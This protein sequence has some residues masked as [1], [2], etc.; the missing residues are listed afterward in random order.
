MR[1]SAVK[2]ALLT[3][4]CTAALFAGGDAVHLETSRISLGRFPA[5]RPPSADLVLV[6]GGA[7]PLEDIRV[8][9]GCGCL[10]AVPDGD[11]VPSGGRMRIRLVLAPEKTSGPFLHSVFIEAGDGVL[12]ASV[13]GEAVPLFTVRPRKS[14]NLGNVSCG[15]AFREEFLL[16][17]AEDVSLGSVSEADAPGTEIVRLSPSS[18]RVILRGTVPEKTG[19]FRI[20]VSIPVASPAG[21]KPVE[22][23]VFGNA[24]SDSGDLTPGEDSRKKENISH[25]QKGVQP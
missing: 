23:V 20:S 8:R 3:L 19:R 4:H 9:T 2:I 15:A 7:A 21:W 13:T 22:L 24:A 10:S 14:A 16:D 1:R 25:R 18:F 12:R 6:N 11:G 17:A 5:N